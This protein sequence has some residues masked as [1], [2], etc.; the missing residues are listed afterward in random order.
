MALIDINIY[1]QVDEE[2]IDTILDS[3]IR[4]EEKIDQ[5]SVTE[6]ELE[7]IANKLRSIRVQVEDTI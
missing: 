6:E 4:I 1:N 3:L 5:N 7:D 2:K